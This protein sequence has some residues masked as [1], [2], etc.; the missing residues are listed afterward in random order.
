M[1]AS[2]A[3]VCSISV[4]QDE[5]EDPL[6][7]SLISSIQPSQKYP[8]LFV[9]PSEPPRIEVVDINTLK[10]SFKNCLHSESVMRKSLEDAKKGINVGR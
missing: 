3:D 4:N 7:M 9:L 8:D 2:V 1:F 10:N 5:S 6:A